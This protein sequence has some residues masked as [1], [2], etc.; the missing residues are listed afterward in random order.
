MILIESVALALKALKHANNAWS[1]LDEPTTEHADSY[2][3]MF[4]SLTEDSGLSWPLRPS[5]SHK[6]SVR[7]LNKPL[8]FRSICA[9]RV[10]H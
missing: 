6:S 8:K 10:V 7:P 9:R 1:C 5:E 4:A 2:Q 3:L